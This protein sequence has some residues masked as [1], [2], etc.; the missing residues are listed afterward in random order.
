MSGEK[1]S[2]N[3]TDLMAY[4]DGQLDDERR[5]MVEAHLAQNAE[6]AAA[7]ARWRRQNE[8]I[9]ALYAPAAG[10]AVPERL[11]V[12]RMSAERHW[13]APRLAG[14]AAAAAVVFALG[15]LSGWFVRGDL[16]PVSGGQAGLVA[17]AVAAHSLYS[18][19]VL[20]P[21]EVK[22]TQ[23]QHLSTWLSKRLDRPLNIPDLRTQGFNLVGGRLLPA[24]SKPA[25][26]FMYED[27]KGRR[28]TLYIVPASNERETAFHYE[29]FDELEAFFW[30]DIHIDCAMVGNLPREELHQI[31]LDAYAQ[32]S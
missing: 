10:E 14:F 6:D 8:A 27:E 31:S 7:V 30:K 4:V 28:I 24:G 25:A 15:S 23:E 9:A 12:R 3:E 16:G 18:G 17:E 20:H 26:Q 1:N 5:R 13:S 29:K 32:L 19:E 22:A 2:V 11:D 21:V